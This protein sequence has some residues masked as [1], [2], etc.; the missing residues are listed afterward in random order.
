MGHRTSTASLMVIGLLACAYSDDS[1]SPPP[2]TPD[3][4]DQYYVGAWE[5]TSVNDSFEGPDRPA[6]A[7]EARTWHV[8]PSEAYD[9]G[10][11]RSPVTVDWGGRSG[12]G[13]WYF[14]LLVRV[15]VSLP[16]QAGGSESYVRR[17]DTQRDGMTLTLLEDGPV[18]HRELYRRVGP[19]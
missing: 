16:T 12:S 4:F 18:F 11:Y 2:P 17:F 14:D 1:S 6:T 5:L 19:P 7:D 13:Y 9:A 10:S 15:E 3:D 8:F